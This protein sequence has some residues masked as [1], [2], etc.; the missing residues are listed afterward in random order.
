[1]S[2]DELLGLGWSA[3]LPKY[4]CEESVKEVGGW[5]CVE[6][7]ELCPSVWCVGSK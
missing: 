3:D 2:A 5:S 1:M 7:G 4:P 6:R